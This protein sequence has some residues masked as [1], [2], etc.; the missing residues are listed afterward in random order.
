MPKDE[1]VKVENSL[2]FSEALKK[3][4]VP[5]ELYLYE[6]GGHGYGMYNKSSPVLWM[7]LVES[8]MKKMRFIK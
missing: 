1:G 7:D 8:W 3:H 6:K 5:V 2:L 4:G